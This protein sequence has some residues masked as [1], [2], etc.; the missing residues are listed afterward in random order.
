MTP[1]EQSVVFE[2]LMSAKLNQFCPEK[3]F[4]LSSQDRPFI[5]AEL[6]KIKRQKSREYI[7]RGKTQKYK[8]L[9][10]L[11]ETKYKIEAGKYLNKNL[12]A[13]RNTNP[14]QAYSILKKMGAEPGDCIDAN[15]FTLPNHESE[16]LSD[17]ES[18]EQIAQHFS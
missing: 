2:Q 8:N 12:E 4:K 5:T 7:K 17:D 9:D 10:K 1:T 6:R 16:N 14:G 15:T 13:L 18:A 11:F 3:E